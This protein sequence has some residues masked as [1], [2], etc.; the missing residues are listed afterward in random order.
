MEIFVLTFKADMYGSNAVRSMRH[1]RQK[2]YFPSYG[3]L[4]LLLT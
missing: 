2:K 3:P 1:E 4:G